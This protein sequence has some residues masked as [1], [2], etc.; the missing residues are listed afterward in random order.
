MVALAFIRMP[1]VV[2]AT[3]M[4]LVLAGNLLSLL[5]AT[6]RVYTED[7]ENCDGTGAVYALRMELLSGLGVLGFAWIMNNILQFK[8]ELRV[9]SGNVATQL[10]AASSLLRLTC[11]AVIELDNELRLIE[12]SPELAC[13][14]LKNSPGAS[15]KGCSFLD[16]IPPDDASRAQENL[17]PAGS[18]NKQGSFSSFGSFN[19]DSEMQITAHAF[20]TR[21]VDSYNGKICTEV[22]QVRY[23]K[24]DGQKY[25]LL[26]L[27]DFTDVKSLA[28]GNAA[29][30]VAEFDNPVSQSHSIS[31]PMFRSPCGSEYG[32]SSGMDSPPAELAPENAFR[33]QHSPRSPTEQKGKDIYMDIDMEG[34]LVHAASTPLTHLA[35]KTLR[36]VF[37]SPHTSLL[38]QSLHSEAKIS[39]RPELMFN[40]VLSYKELPLVGVAQGI[41]GTMQLTKTRYDQVH[42]LMAFATCQPE[43]SR[44]ERRTRHKPSYQLQKSS[45]L[46]SL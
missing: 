15:L 22:F 44:F 30:S 3:S 8:A 12:D 1:A 40:R 39:Q 18:M 14:L 17:A 45:S 28:G 26:G 19:S 7:F 32:G 4:P 5:H 34:L 38:L 2:F 16:F 29:D 43:R 6:F 42:V 9:E 36:E 35:G 46:T 24:L 13:M 10:S 23:T 37:P 33:V 21:L 20:H 31:F 25:Y 27:R 41:S 11:D